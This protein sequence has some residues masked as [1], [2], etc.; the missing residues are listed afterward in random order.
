MCE[1]SSYIFQAVSPCRQIPRCSDRDVRQHQTAPALHDQRGT[2]EGGRL[3]M[4][5]GM[6]RSQRDQEGGRGERETETSSNQ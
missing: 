2:R 4:N 6:N 5:G 1:S 3:K